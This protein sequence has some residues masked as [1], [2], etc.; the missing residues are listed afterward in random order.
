MF[1]RSCSTLLVFYV[2]GFVT[3]GAL[4]GLFQPMLRGRV[5]TTIGCILGGVIVVFAIAIGDGKGI[6]GIDWIAYP[7]MGIV[8]GGAAAYGLL[9][10]S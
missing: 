2:G 7:A 8:F 5:G 6:H 10:E 4:F 3:A 1:A 9:E